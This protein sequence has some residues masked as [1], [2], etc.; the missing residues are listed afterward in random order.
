MTSLT[1]DY[2][3]VGGGAA[4]MAFV[5]ELIHHSKD[6]TV[7]MVDRCLEE[8]FH[9]WHSLR[10]ASQ[11]RGSLGGRLWVCPASPACRLLW[12]QLQATGEQPGRRWVTYVWSVSYTAQVGGRADLASKAQILAYYELVLADLKVSLISFNISITITSTSR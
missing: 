9:E 12:G 2:L 4:G 11:A 7:V 6:L 8:T 1:C 5:D 10:Q 3:V